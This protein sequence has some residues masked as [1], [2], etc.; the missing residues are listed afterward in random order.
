ME[1]SST[2][3]ITTRAAGVRF[4]LISAAISF[5]FFLAL[6][7]SG[8]QAGQ[9]I[10]SWIGYVITAALIFFAQKYFK[11]NGDGYMSY[12]QGMG[13]AFWEGL[14]STLIYT[15]LFYVYVKF[16]D[17]GFID[18]IK[19][20]QMQDMHDKGM[21]QEQIDQAM[22]FASGFMTPEAMFGFGLVFGILGFI[23]IGLIVTIFTQ[24]KNPDAIV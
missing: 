9:G 12:G 17:S 3:S 21:S 5:I 10:W 14:V 20:K 16:I 13:V 15:P 18:M 4:G 19:D 6:T 22:S 1:E 7:M 23:I 11:D 2:P 24:K 8:I